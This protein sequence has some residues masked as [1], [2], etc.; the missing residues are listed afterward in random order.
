MKG[1]ISGSVKTS[2]ARKGYNHPAKPMKL[3]PTS[4]MVFPVKSGKKK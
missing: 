1:K 3:N 2:G 4:P